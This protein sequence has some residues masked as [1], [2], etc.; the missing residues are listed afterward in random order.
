[1]KKNAKLASL[2]TSLKHVAIFLHN[3]DS[4]NLRVTKTRQIPPRRQ[5]ASRWELAKCYFYHIS[6]FRSF[7][8]GLGYVSPFRVSVSSFLA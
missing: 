8:N 7:G 5:M 2:Q 1:M 3:A 6:G 4:P